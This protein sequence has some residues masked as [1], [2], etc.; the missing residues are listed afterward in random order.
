MKG[1]VISRIET[2]ETIDQQIDRILRG[3]TFEYIQRGCY[4]F[5]FRITYPGVSEFVNHITGQPVNV[6]LLKVQSINMSMVPTKPRGDELEQTDCGL[7]KQTQ[8]VRLDAITK[9]VTL[10]QQLYE[11]G[12]REYQIPPCP[13]IL[14]YKA[15]PI[16][17]LESFIAG[18]IIYSYNGKVI[19]GLDY[20]KFFAAI[21]LMEYVPSTDIL[22]VDDES[23]ELKN[24]AFTMYCLALKCGVNQV[25]ALPQNY[26]LGEDGN[27]TMIDFGQ[28]RVLGPSTL[29]LVKTAIEAAEGGGRK[30]Y[31]RL[32]DRLTGLNGEKLEKWLFWRR[33]PRL[34]EIVPLRR[35][36]AQQCL[37]GLCVP[38]S[39]VPDIKRVS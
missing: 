18:K 3:S 24:K 39:Y 21:I 9:E 8:Q 5:V 15:L 35:E 1:G 7:P 30:E 25:D 31:D 32:L 37:T 10:Q 6:F 29:G 22:R 13:A 28:A 4:G 16:R 14:F 27:V 23:Q 17:E 36:V 34:V 33:T 12:L 26:L 2:G 20:D 19:A 38:A 11:T